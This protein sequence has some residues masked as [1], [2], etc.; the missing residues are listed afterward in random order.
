MP[1]YRLA[2]RVGLMRPGVRPQQV[3]PAAAAAARRNVFVESTGLALVRGRP[4]L[5]VRFT[6]E[7][8]QQ[9]RA[10]ARQVVEATGRLA[11]VEG[12]EVRLRRGGEWVWIG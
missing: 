5:T 3:E 4:R 1:S 7:D 9:A 11:Q 6:G 2:M 10:V 12:A 8:D